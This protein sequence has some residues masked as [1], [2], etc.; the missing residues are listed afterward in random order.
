M[1]YDYDL[2]P[3]KRMVLVISKDQVC[4][5]GNNQF[6]VV[7]DE[8]T[9]QPNSLKKN[10]LRQKNLNP[11]QKTIHYS[12]HFTADCGNFTPGHLTQELPIEGDSKRKT[13]IQVDAENGVTVSLKN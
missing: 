6:T 1:I 11:N 7:D 3:Q 10:T 8:P 12:I 13:H 9:G 5:G 2:A 4:V